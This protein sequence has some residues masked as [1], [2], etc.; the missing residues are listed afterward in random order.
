MDAFY[1]NDGEAAFIDKI[2]AYLGITTD[3]VRI[4]AI[5]I[6]SVII[7]YYIDD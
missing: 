7:D 6:G 1:K 4:V 5:R 3:R 2:S